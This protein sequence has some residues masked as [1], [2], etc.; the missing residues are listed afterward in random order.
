MK[1]TQNFATAVV[2]SKQ[3]VRKRSDNA[4]D[5]AAHAQKKTDGPED[6]RTVKTRKTALQN[7]KHQ[8]RHT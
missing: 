7:Y 6:R 4:F 1:R 2:A 8:N 5:V 3:E